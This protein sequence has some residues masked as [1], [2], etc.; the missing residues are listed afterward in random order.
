MTYDSLVN[1]SIPFFLQV[2]FPYFV[3]N[4]KKYIYKI[5]NKKESK[6]PERKIKGL[7]KNNIPQRK[8][9]K[10]WK[11]ASPNATT[12]Y[13]VA[14]DYGKVSINAIIHDELNCLNL[15]CHDL[16]FIVVA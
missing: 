11:C 12:F 5:K 1:M 6:S 9:N 8:R 7:R 14:D 13:F 4:K 16:N 15:T 2:V 10:T 3:K